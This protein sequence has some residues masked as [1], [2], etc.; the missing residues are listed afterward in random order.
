MTYIEAKQVLGCA[1][2]WCTN[3]RAPTFG[4]QVE[5]N[6][7]VLLNVEPAPFNGANPYVF[8]DVF[9]APPVSNRTEYYY[10]TSYEED[11]IPPEFWDIIFNSNE[12]YPLLNSDEIRYIDV[13]G[14]RQC[15]LTK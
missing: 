1:S 12:W 9:G 5:K 7:R 13:L 10:N 3:H 15:F 4:I 14:E 8:F 6:K 11:N 2:V